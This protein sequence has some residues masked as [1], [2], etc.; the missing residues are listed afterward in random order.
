MLNPELRP[1]TIAD[2]DAQTE[3]LLR[4][5]GHPEPPLDLRFVRELLCLDRNY[6]STENDSAML[7]LSV[8]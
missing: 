6:Y 8:G 5:L 3:K 2:L 7:K 1:R 4:G